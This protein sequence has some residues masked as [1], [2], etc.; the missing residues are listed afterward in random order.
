MLSSCNVSL[1]TEAALE[2]MRLPH[3]RG[4][5]LG[6]LLEAFHYEG[7]FVDGFRPCNGVLRRSPQLVLEAVSR[8]PES[9][10]RVPLVLRR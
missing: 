5:S 2:A 1:E 10:W 3:L 6:L 8:A 4:Q 9:K 7:D